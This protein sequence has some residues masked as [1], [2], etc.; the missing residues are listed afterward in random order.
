M[1]FMLVLGT[2]VFFGYILN[3]NKDKT[4]DD[5]VSETFGILKDRTSDW[6]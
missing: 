5:F 6:R 4:I 1:K 2:G 3:R